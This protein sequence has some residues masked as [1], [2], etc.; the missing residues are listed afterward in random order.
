VKVYELTDDHR[1][2]TSALAIPGA[3]Y[4]RARKAYV[5]VDPTPRAAAAALALFKDTANRYPELMELRDSAYGDDVRPTDYATPAG[6]ELNPVLN[7][8]E[9]FDWQ[10]K[11]GGYLEAILRRDGIANILWE[12]GLGK[13]VLSA[14]FIQKLGVLRT[15]VV[16]RNDAKEPVWK[17]ELEELL[18]DHEIVVLPNAKAKREKELRY[19]AQR[20]R[21]EVNEPYVF[22]VHYES[23]A[24]IAGDRG[25]GK[26]W[27]KLGDWDLMIFDEGHRLATITETQMGKA[28]K[29]V[30]KRSRLAINLTGTPIMNHPTDLFGQLHY[31][32]PDIYKYSRKN[33]GDRFLDYLHVDGR[34]VCIGWKP[35]NIQALRDELGVFSVLRRRAEVLDLPPLTKQKIVL[36]LHREQQRAYDQMLEQYYTEVK[37]GALIAG[38]AITQ[39]NHLR[40]IATWVDG[41]PSAKLDF[42]VNEIEENPDVQFVVFTWYKAPGRAL[43][44]RLGET[45]VVVDGD[46]PAVERSRNLE[47]HR[48]GDARVLVGS[49]ATIGESLNLQYCHE[50]IRLDRH[51]NPGVN[52]QVDGRLQRAG[53]EYPVYLRDLI[54]RNTVDELNVMPSVENKEHFMNVVFGRV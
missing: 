6:L 26:G 3:T 25:R 17:A 15:L 12:M 54:A 28:V 39:L 4:D 40:Q 30:R 51:W 53:Q 35:E 48:K 21:G 10:N 5:V 52:K 38:S 7:G 31:L 9:L 47:L 18:P 11:D 22:I 14:G 50:A 34:D 8:I 46:A 42:A 41:L 32:R 13:T 43:A 24:L 27:D 36:P 44:A 45:A 1:Y 37:G 19:V 20:G 49:I 16:C 29:K 2:R 33:F 23:L